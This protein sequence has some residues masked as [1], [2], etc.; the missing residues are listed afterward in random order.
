M[1]KARKN[2]W[3]IVILLALACLAN[4]GITKFRNPGAQPPPALDAVPGRIGT[5]MSR[6]DI[7]MPQYVLDILRPD[8]LISREYEDSEGRTIFLFAQFHGTNRWGAHQ[9][10][11]CFTSQGWSIEY[12]Q[13]SSTVSETLPGTDVTANRFIARRGPAT[14]I[15]LYWWFSS[16][17]FQTASRTAQMLDSLRTQILTGEGGGNGFIE[18]ATAV[19]PETQAEDEERLRRFAAALVPIF[20]GIIEHRAERPL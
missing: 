12:Q 3:L 16:N 13:L 20:G 2:G 5:W 15:V 18:V 14:Q 6:G 11:V 19:N 9:P 10:E 17:N 4:A 1:A 8:A 7:T